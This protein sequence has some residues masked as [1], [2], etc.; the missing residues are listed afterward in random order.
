[1]LTLRHIEVFHAIMQTGSVTGA[2]RLLNVSQPA[3]SSVLKHC[4]AR[5]RIK[6]FE[7]AGGRLRPTPEARALFPDASAIYGRLDAMSRLMQDLA[8]GRLG[9]VSLAASFPIANG[10]LAKAVATFL[11]ERP[12]IQ[13][14]LQSLTSPQVIDRVA[15][16][17]VEIGIAYGPVI[18]A[19]VETEHLV[20][21]AVA[22]VM[23]DDH[24]LARLEE[25]EVGEL[26]PYPIIT[27]LP[28]AL[29]R[30]YVDGALNRAGVVPNISV[31]VSLSLTGMIMAYHGAGIALVEPFLLNSLRLEG[32]VARPLRPRI[33]LNTLLIRARQSPRSELM[34]QFVVHLRRELAAMPEMMLS[35]PAAQDADVALPGIPASARPARHSR[36][37]AKTG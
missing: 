35:P 12:G 8:G 34:D 29:L 20:R 23:R 4:E 24:P 28:Q 11:Q 27:Y 33:E 17:E 19:E 2:A 30:G 6:L 36:K 15:S 3:V 22:C 25:I 21:S 16:R 31:Q 18:N 1:M 32:L 37:R 5:A 10:Y 13:V 9:S 14:A 26:A 7:R